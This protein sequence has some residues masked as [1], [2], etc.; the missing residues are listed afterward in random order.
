MIEFR[1]ATLD[2][3]LTAI[4]PALLESGLQIASSKGPNRELLGV[5]LEL[6]NPR[7][8]I[9]RSY[10]RGRLFSALGELNWYLAGS[11][12]EPFISTYL[13]SAA[14][15]GAKRRGRLVG[16]YGPRLRGRRHNAQ[17][18]N[19]IRLLKERP[20]TRQAVIQLFDRRDLHRGVADL[21]C[22]CTIQ[23]LLRNG[24]LSAVTYMRSNDAYRGLPHDVYCFTMLQEIVARSVGA[25]L[26]N[27]QHV[28]GS[29]HLY[30]RDAPRAQQYLDEG[31]H[32]ER[33]QMRPMPPG[34]PW[35]EISEMLRWERRS[36]KGFASLE[37]TIKLP[38]TYWGDIGRVIAAFHIGRDGDG[39]LRRIADSLS[40]P[41]FR[42]YLLERSRQ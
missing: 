7:A 36:R 17:I 2:A 15:D 4:Y 35:P 25:E 30:D 38:E 37:E 33:E 34:D 42:P 39:N 27:Y 21:P 9:S 11:S 22:T 26:G 14:Y 20:D 19:I 13:G 29:L 32:P 41:F 31:V 16:A 10:L 12:R 5:A 18:A 3:I 28:I 1:G 6:D 8:R 24:K 40:D 23:F